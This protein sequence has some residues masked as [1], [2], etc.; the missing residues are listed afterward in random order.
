MN[1]LTSAYGK[2]NAQQWING[3]V[4]AGRLNYLNKGSPALSGPS[5]LQ[6]PAGVP[7]ANGALGRN[8]RLSEDLRKYR[9]AA[10]VEIEHAFPAHAGMN[11]LMSVS[12]LRGQVHM[13]AR[14]K[15][16]T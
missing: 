16:R 9:S 14:L 13:A 6:L 10:A 11:R 1:V 8:V 15:E 3:Q 5:R 2:D 4:A 12:V 7:K